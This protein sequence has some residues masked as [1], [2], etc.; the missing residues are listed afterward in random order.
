MRLLLDTNVLIAAFIARGVC[1]E[2]FEHCVRQHA[3]IA[4]GFILHEF[5]D[6]LVE[7][8]DFSRQEAREARELLAARVVALEPDPLQE[9]VCRDADDDNILAAAVAGDCACIVTGDKDL[10]SLGA[11]RGI[12]IISPRDFWRYENAGE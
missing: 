10:L 3:L 5:Q 4:S 1:S 6:K 2:L 11:F 7:K 12:D 9:S 8:F